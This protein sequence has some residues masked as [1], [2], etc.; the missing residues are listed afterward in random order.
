MKPFS[1]LGGKILLLP[2]TAALLFVS[3]PAASFAAPELSVESAYEDPVNGSTLYSVNYMSGN[4]YESQVVEQ[5]Q[6]GHFIKWPDWIS[7]VQLD[8]SGRFLIF[9]YEADSPFLSHVYAPETR[10]ISAGNLY[11]LSPDGNWGIMERLTYNSGPGKHYFM[12]NMQTGKVTLFLNSDRSAASTWVGNHQLILR[13]FSET[14][15]QNVILSYD[16]EKSITTVL[17]QGSLYNL[18]VSKGLL[19]YAKNEPERKLWIYDLAT[20]KSR[21]AADEKEVQTLFYDQ[22][23]SGTTQPKPTLP[24]DLDINA[25]SEAKIPVVRHDESVVAIN[26]LSTPVLYSFYSGN[27]LWVPL[28]QVADRFGWE[29]H[30]SSAKAPYLYTVTAS[31]AIIS[32][33]PSNSLVFDDTLFI[34]TAQIRQLG[35]TDISVYAKN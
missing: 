4:Q 13:S 17:T 10:T 29:I 32:L 33:T 19:L 16:P 9:G 30:S 27:S 28:R 24:A 25:L 8:S 3:V 15:K 23:N 2:L 34:S 22:Y 6:D 20:G 7:G 18:N 14:Y 11:Q 1:K 12:K 31:N 5:Q 35:Y 26:G 21:L